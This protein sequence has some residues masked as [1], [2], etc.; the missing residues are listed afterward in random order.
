MKL[1]EIIQIPPLFM[2]G[3][4]QGHSDKEYIV[5]DFSEMGKTTE[6]INPEDFEELITL[7]Q[8]FIPMYQEFIKSYASDFNFNKNIL[9]YE[10]TEKVNDETLKVYK[11]TLDD[12]TFKEFMKYA[13]ET[14]IQSDAT[15]D[16][17]E[18]Y[19]QLI[20]LSSKSFN[21]SNEQTTIQMQRDLEELKTM[22]S[23][24]SKTE[25][26][27]LVDEF[28]RELK[29]IQILG[30]QGLAIQFKINED[31]YIVHTDGT[32]HMRFHTRQFEN[33]QKEE[34]E[35]SSLEEDDNVTVDIQLEFNTDVYNINQDFDIEM[36]EVT[37]DN[38]ISLQQ[39]MEIEQAIAEP[40]I[41]VFVDGYPVDLEVAPVMENGRVLVP[42]RPLAE[43]MGM[44]VSWDQSTQMVKIT[45]DGAEIELTLNSNEAYI[46]NNKIL[47]E[48]PVRMIENTTF[49]PVRFV[50]EGLGA[51]VSWDGITQIVYITH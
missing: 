35:I 11:L 41:K 1:K 49:V 30:D 7:S 22:F 26:L 12:E 36:P 14:L 32:I 27:V 6:D 16:F 2:M 45:K 33:F 20:M 24:E 42:I 48:V 31:G 38:S 29:D 51:D 40:G 23:E 34:N 37:D 21:S 18:E 28:F 46:N 3:M 9:T 50:G 17:L 47:L 4:P 5:I 43:A 13:T 44:D 25:A 15:E 19:I 10:G 39:I 8:E